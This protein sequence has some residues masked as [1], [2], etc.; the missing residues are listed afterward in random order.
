LRHRHPFV[1][2]VPVFCSR[3]RVPERADSDAGVSGRDTNR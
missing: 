2:W 3:Q 1:K